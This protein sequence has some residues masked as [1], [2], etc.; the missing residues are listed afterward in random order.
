M[1]DELQPVEAPET[2]ESPQ[3]VEA[4]VET[5]TTE[6][7]EVPETPTW[8][9]E[10]DKLDPKELRKHPRIAG[11]IGN[12][13]QLAM[14]RQRERMEE[15]ARRNAND[16]A[17]QALL[18]FTEDNAEY[19]KERYPKVYEHLMNLQ[20]QRAQRETEGLRSKTRH[21]M[22]QAL[23][24]AFA[25]IP[26]WQELTEADHEDLAKKVIGKSDDEVIPIFQ[27]EATTKV[28]TRIAQKL[29]EQWKAK[30]LAKEREAIRQ[31]EAAKLLKNSEAPDTRRPSGLPARTNINNMSDEEFDDYWNKRFR[32]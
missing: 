13:L 31:E 9:Q 27:K 17:E 1:A 5:S 18:G 25:E 2:P 3:V 6:T 7:P 32:N 12:E 19:L 23:G 14:Q 24:R 21:E 22:A 15:E 28:A 11:M 26:E 20:A 10:L 30:D 8:Q 4:P 16:Q 29:H